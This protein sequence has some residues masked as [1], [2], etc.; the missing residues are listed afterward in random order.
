MSS[1]DT[2]ADRLGR[3]LARL[4]FRRKLNALIAVPLVMISVLFAVYV[5]G[6]VNQA[7]SAANEADLLS[8]SGTVAQLVDDVQHEQ[9]QAILYYE[10]Y[11]ETP[12]NRAK[13]IPDRD[14]YVAAQAATDAQVDKVRQTFG[15]AI[16]AD[17]ATAL[18]VLEAGL[19]VPR[20]TITSGQLPTDNIDA[21]YG[22]VAESLIDGLGLSAP[23][24]NQSTARL[25]D[26]L[27]SL[28]RADS[29]HA[30]FETAVVSALTRDSDATTQF[31][32]AE[33]SIQLYQAQ[34]ARFTAIAPTDRSNALGG[35]EFGPDEVNLE[36]ALSSL[37]LKTSALT[38]VSAAD[39]KAARAQALALQPSAV[40]ESQKRARITG[41]LIPEIAGEAQLD[42]T[43]AWWRASILL[44]LAAVIFFGWVLLLALIRRSILGPL[45]QVTEAARRV[46][47]LSA[48][49]LSR[50][51]DE[52]AV[53][54]AEGPPQ[55]ED[56]PIPAEDEIGELAKAFNQVQSTAGA[57]LE[58]QVQSRRNIAEMFG[59]IGRRVANLTGRQLSLIDSVERGETDPELLEQL[60][61]IDHIA[62]RL[63]RNADSLMLL[64]G[65]RETELDGRPAELSHV[66]RAALGQIEGFER[67]RLT[68]RVDATVAPDVVGDLVLMLA[69][70]L[71]NAVSFS[72][73][74]SEVAV[75]LREEDG[76]AVLEIVDHGLGMSSERLSEENAR[77]VRRERLD[78]APTRVLGLFV[79]GVLARR[80]NIQV[81]LSRT[82]G[83]GVTCQ[84]VVPSELVTPSAPRAG[85][86]WS[87]AGALPPA[88]KAALAL[89]AS[90]TATI[91]P[92]AAR[93]HQPTPAAPAVAV[94]AADLEPE[95]DLF[96]PR[97]EPDSTHARPDDPAPAL[98]HARTANATTDA[99]LPVR[100][101]PTAEEPPAAPTAPQTSETPQTPP[102]SRRERP[103]LGGGLRRRVRGATLREGLSSAD[104]LAAR[105]AD[106]DEVRS[107]LEEF[108]AAVSR[109]ERDS[110]P[111]I[112]STTST[113]STI[114]TTSNPERTEGVGQ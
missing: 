90:A 12:T 38:E 17:L 19:Q 20:Q 82:P 44:G 86:T 63:Q 58:R 14:S 42:S 43:R 34:V 95:P 5:N 23:Q 70:L 93:R 74:H 75:T 46:S 28:L 41:E 48:Q 73:A 2:L 101:A 49:E 114:G 89:G 94:R 29:A 35:I 64:A 83:G 18:Q 36:S 80:W 88:A 56:L 15:S 31:G 8:R 54:N 3:R 66:V 110:A 22:N 112:S 10:S 77:L 27:D 16:P 9:S 26:Q 65:I 100:K 25:S 99:G 68:A 52:D 87:P 71:E 62:V 76:Q 97:R 37:W 106:P 7:E 4:P 96:A 108:E 1:L 85:L 50:V 69:E 59:N 40:R 53:D 45:Q 55:L 102:E 81:T 92:P 32:V 6:Q 33:G 39:L 91:L 109:A 61:R 24:S 107:S 84:V 11:W 113:T 51:A 72:P 111:G 103:G 21:A 47:E 105:P 98:P 67:V 104:R 79:V 13:S 57:L 78:L 30:Q 60:Y